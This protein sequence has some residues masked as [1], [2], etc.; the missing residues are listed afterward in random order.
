MSGVKR[1]NFFVCSGVE[2][3]M[4]DPCWNFNKFI[5]IGSMSHLQGGNT[6]YISQ[7]CCATS[8]FNNE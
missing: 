4:P 8:F 6:A 3:L 7:T 5:T 2:H 1:C